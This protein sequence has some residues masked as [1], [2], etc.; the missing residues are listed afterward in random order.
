MI[1]RR[2][3]ALWIAYAVGG[4]CRSRPAREEPPAGSADSDRRRAAVE[5]YAERAERLYGE[6][7]ASVRAL[8]RTIQA[9]LARP[10]AAS[11]AAARE[12]WLAARPPYAMTEVYRF[13][14]GPIDDVET[15]VNAWPIDESFIDG[16]EGDP[17]AGLVQN[18]AELPEI[19]AAAL[20]AR[21]ERDG[22]TSIST[23]FHAIEFLLWGQDRFEAGP[24]RRPAGD[25][26]PG[27]PHAARRGRY[28]QVATEL[29]VTHLEQVHEAWSTGHASNYRARLLEAPADVALGR[30]F[31][32]LAMLAGPEL[33]GER[34]TVAIETKDQE[35]EHSCFSDSTHD[36]IVFNVLGIREAYLGTLPTSARDT[37]AATAP[38]RGRVSLH[39]LVREREAALA[40]RLDTATQD[41]LSAARGI[42]APCDQ[43]IRGDDESP[44]RK[45]ARRA[46]ARLRELSDLLSEAA[47]RLAVQ[48]EP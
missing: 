18:P 27:A 9:F 24:G 41:A 3:A 39:D 31:R 11:L 4:A 12:A 14:G 26:L 13:Y 38:P 15:W 40:R 37:G 30:A 48:V 5:G 10:S 22:E 6:A 34:L 17:R 36:D 29:L 33:S 25:Y 46:A 21:N 16:V 43:A 28:L 1:A 7:V 23:G 32:G 47:A 45:A 19:T 35:D 20:V 2:E 8:A 44:G 42:P